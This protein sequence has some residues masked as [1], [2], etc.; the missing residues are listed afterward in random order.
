MAGKTGVFCAHFTRMRINGQG[1]TLSAPAHSIA[2]CIPLY[3]RIQPECSPIPPSAQIAPKPTE[4]AGGRENGVK[5]I[6][7][8]TLVKIV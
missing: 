8:D 7:R 3:I 2:F 1:R 5:G 6:E 4:P